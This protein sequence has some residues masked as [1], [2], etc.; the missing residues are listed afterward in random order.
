LL[1][2]HV[3]LDGV[4]IGI[5]IDNHA[6]EALGP[7]GD[8]PLET[9]PIAQPQLLAEDAARH[10]NGTAAAHL[11]IGYLHGVFGHVPAPP[12]RSRRSIVRRDSYLG[13]KHQGLTCRVVVVV[14]VAGGGG[15]TVIVVSPVVRVLLLAV[16]SPFSLP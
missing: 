8:N 2:W 5:E 11:L 7:A 4:G 13:L 1:V 14:V 12:I 9:H 15:K 3:D 16:S 6:D 10:R